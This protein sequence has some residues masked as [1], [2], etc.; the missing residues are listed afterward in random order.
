MIKC[1]KDPKQE[2]RWIPERSCNAVIPVCSY[3]SLTK[4][5]TVACV[6]YPAETLAGTNFEAAAFSVNRLDEPKEDECL[7]VTEPHPSASHKVRINGETFDA[8][9]VGGVAAGSFSAADAYR[10]FHQ[11]RCYELD[12]RVAFL[13]MGALDPGTVKE[14]DYKA[15]DR[16]LRS[17]LSTFKFSK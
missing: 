16:A 4:D 6:A 17:V 11:N 7:R 2:D 13:S 9:D 14:F 5:A 12:V 1:E 3:A 15:V 10:N 8:F